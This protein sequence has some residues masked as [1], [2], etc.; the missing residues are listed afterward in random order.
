MHKLNTCKKS[1]I[2]RLYPDSQL[3]TGV[4]QFRKEKI[5]GKDLKKRCDVKKPEVLDLSIARE[6][7]LDKL[8]DI[9]KFQF[10]HR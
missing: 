1:I 2:E 9:C 8:P 10:P 3:K 5:L 4:I 6:T 7:V